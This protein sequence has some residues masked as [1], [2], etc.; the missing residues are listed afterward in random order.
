VVDHRLFKAITAGQSRAVVVNGFY[1]V[2]EEDR[3]IGIEKT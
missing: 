1:L 3:K 2:G